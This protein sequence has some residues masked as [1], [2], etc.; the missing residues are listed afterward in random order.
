[1]L[2]AAYVIAAPSVPDSIQKLPALHHEEIHDELGQY[3]L[4]YITADGTIVYEKGWLVPNPDGEGRVMVTEGE[5]TYTGDDGK[6][7]STKYTAGFDGFKPEGAH[8]VVPPL[9]P[10]V[11]PADV[12]V[13]AW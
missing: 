12:L 13:V 9:E 2:C 8:L 1:M 11:V 5:V 6:V 4:R 7:Y 10:A 3:S